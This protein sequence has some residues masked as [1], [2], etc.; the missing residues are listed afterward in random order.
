MSHTDTHS[1]DY[2]W[3]YASLGAG[4]FFVAAVLFVPLLF[5]ADW[6][7]SWTTTAES[8][9]LIIVKVPH[10]EQYQREQWPALPETGDSSFITNPLKNRGPDPTPYLTPD[11]TSLSLQE[12]AS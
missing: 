7:G 12:L 4:L 5:G 1:Y 2:T 9:S 10:G 6:G 11:V 3:P 8:D